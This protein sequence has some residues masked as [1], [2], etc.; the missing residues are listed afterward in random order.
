MV[1]EDC[2]LEALS[3]L[4][5]C[6]PWAVHL[7]R[8]FKERPGGPQLTARQLEL[9]ELVRERGEVSFSQAAQALGLKE[10]EVRREFAVL[11]HLEL[12]RATL[13]AGLVLI[14]PF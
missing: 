12:L 2:Y 11:R 1:C 7:G 5:V 9:L 3:P 8:G 6:D 4:R 10:E 13:R 14:T